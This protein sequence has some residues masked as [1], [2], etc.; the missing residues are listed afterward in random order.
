MPCVT[1]A[2]HGSITKPTDTL[3]FCSNTLSC[4]T[5]RK[6][7]TLYTIGVLH[8]LFSVQ[9]NQH[10]KHTYNTLKQIHSSGSGERATLSLLIQTLYPNAFDAAHRQFFRT[11]FPLRLSNTPHSKLR[12]LL[13]LLINKTCMLPTTVATYSLTELRP[14]HRVDSHAARVRFLR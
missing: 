11:T 13:S 3:T 9:V 4:M 10:T 12:V 7:I 5:G 14:P 8:S 6:H 2:L 1:T